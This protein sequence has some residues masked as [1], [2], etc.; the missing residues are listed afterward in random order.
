MIF[1]SK[2]SLEREDLERL[3][4]PKMR[5]SLGVDSEFGVDMVTR[6]SYAVKHLV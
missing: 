1:C 2:M 6:V 4:C 5:F 3:G